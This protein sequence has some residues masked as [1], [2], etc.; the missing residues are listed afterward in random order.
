VPNKFYF[1]FITISIVLQ[2]A[3]LARAENKMSLTDCNFNKGPCTKRLEKSDLIITLDIN[4]KPLTAM[5]ELQFSVMINQD[6]VPVSNATVTVDLTMPGMY[7]GK[8]QVL[9]KPSKDNKYEGSGII[10]MCP[11]GA[12][13]WMAEVKVKINDIEHSANYVFEL[14]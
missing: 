11:S 3:V 4:P 6:I 12:K 13:A 8:N 2:L 9:L 10:P 14:K 5:S 7:M 1:F